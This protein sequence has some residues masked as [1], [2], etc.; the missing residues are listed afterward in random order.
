MES[1]YKKGEAEFIV[2]VE[3]AK[4]LPN[5]DNHQVL[6][7]WAKE[8]KNPQQRGFR[9]AA[10]VNFR[11]ALGIDANGKSIGNKSDVLDLKNASIDC[12]PEIE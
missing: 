4:V 11:A 7:K 6:K 2:D 8:G 9:A 12:L 10:A 1:E 3:G 5:E